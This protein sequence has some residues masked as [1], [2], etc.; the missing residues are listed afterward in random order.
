MTQTL[1]NR[2]TTNPSQAFAAC[3][4]LS[5]NHEDLDRQTMTEVSGGVP[6]IV[7]AIAVGAAAGA[8][9]GVV[10]V[11]V[12]NPQQAV[13]A[14][15]WY[16]DRV[17]EGYDAVEGFVEDVVDDFVEGLVNISVGDGW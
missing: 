10:A 4:A 9:G 7:V 6:P 16:G 3:P 5:I 2:M 13:E 17:S 11:V 8:I 14:A 1:V 15:D 12:T